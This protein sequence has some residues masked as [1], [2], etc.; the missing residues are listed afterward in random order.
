MLQL[1]FPVQL[2]CAKL[3]ELCQKPLV[4]QDLAEAQ[5]LQAII[6]RADHIASGVGVSMMHR[7]TNDQPC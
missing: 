3:W 1:T 5:A 4:G 7:K 6:A 2:A